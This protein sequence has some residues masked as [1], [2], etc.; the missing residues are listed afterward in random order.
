MSRF[1]GSY[2]AGNTNVLAMLIC[3]MAITEGLA[4]PKTLIRICNGMASPQAPINIQR[5]FVYVEIQIAENDAGPFYFGM[6][7]PAGGVVIKSVIRIDGTPPPGAI[8]PMELP[9]FN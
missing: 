5:L 9:L 2:L 6:F 8:I 3:E 1:G 4:G 7:D